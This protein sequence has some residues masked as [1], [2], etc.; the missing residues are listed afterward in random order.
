MKFTINDSRDIYYAIRVGPFPGERELGCQHD[1]RGKKLTQLNIINQT[2]PEHAHVQVQ[3]FHLGHDPHAHISTMLEDDVF[4][5]SSPTVVDCDILEAAK[6]N[7]QPLATGRR[8]TSLSS[9][10][11]TPHAQRDSKLAATK[12]RL[13]MNIQVAL[14]DEDDDALEAYCQLVNWTMDHYP[15][16]NSAESGLLELLEEATRV[17]KDHRDGKWRKET[18]YLKLWLLYAGYVDKPVIVYKFLL[19]NDIGTEHAL[20]YEEFS[21][22]LERDKRWVNHKV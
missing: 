21:A 8:V 16:G 22:V 2:R 15:E 9:I 19:A 5:D 10:L 3:L 18:K 17:L 12:R 13:R 6:E 11:A 14:S 7:V 4:D 20:F 1:E